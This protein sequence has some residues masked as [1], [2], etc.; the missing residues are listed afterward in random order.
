M[1]VVNRT[2][3]IGYGHYFCPQRYRL[4]RSVISHIA[5][6]RYSHCLTPER[7]LRLIQHLFHEIQKPETGRLRPD[8]AAAPRRPFACQYAG[9]IVPY[10]FV[11][12]E[13][14]SDFAFSHADIA[15]RNIGVGT[16]M[17]I[18][19]GHKTLAEPHDFIVRL[20]AGIEVR[21]AFASAQRKSGK[22]IFESLFKCEE[23]QYT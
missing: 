10:P 1:F 4:N 23:L 21:A 16:D 19:F 2:V 20:V 17:P 6:A 13:Q 22:A 8:E 7:L 5:R 11:L 9:K 12:A 18:K 14:I 15:G 3:A